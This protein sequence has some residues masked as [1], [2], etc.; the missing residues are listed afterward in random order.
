[1]SKERDDK[2]EPAPK[3]EHTG[4]ETPPLTAISSYAPT[5]D[6]YD[7]ALL[8]GLKFMEEPSLTRRQ[9][10]LIEIVERIRIGDRAQ[11]VQALRDFMKHLDDSGERNQRH[12]LADIEARQSTYLAASGT[13]TQFNGILAA[14][15]A[16]ALAMLELGSLKLAFSAALAL[17]VLAAATL[18]WAARPIA[19]KREPTPTMTLI[20]QVALVFQTFRNY[21]RGWRMTM[22]ALLVTAIAG[23]LLGLQ[24]LGISPPL[25]FLFK[26]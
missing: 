6:R 9:D 25:S 22:L 17:H 3:V 5:E 11:G 13:L 18:C 19:T 16:G 15:L 26:Q 21:Q 14:V 8:D 20:G 12:R 2:S 4:V 23:T 24:I 10:P 1:V 7:A